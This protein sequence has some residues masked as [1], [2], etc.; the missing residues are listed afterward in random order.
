MAE[1]LFTPPTVEEGPAGWEN[2]LLQR[3]RLPRGITVVQRL[4]G[5]FY[6][7]RYPA[8]IEL[9]TAERFWLGG[10][11]HVI[12]ETAKNQLTAAGYGSYIA[13]YYP[14]GSYGWGGYGDGTYGGS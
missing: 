5:G 7:T 3:F 8:Q 1:Y 4:D 14:P 13:E 9:E 12:D 2:R 10:H 6:Q 11:T